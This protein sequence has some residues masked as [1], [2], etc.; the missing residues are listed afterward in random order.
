M[1]LTWS[2]PE[3][4]MKPMVY[5]TAVFSMVRTVH[6]TVFIGSALS[7]DETKSAFN[8]CC[9]SCSSSDELKSH[10]SLN[11]TAKHFKLNTCGSSF[12]EYQTRKGLVLIL[13]G[14]N[15][16]F[17]KT[18]VNSNPL[19]IIWQEASKLDQRIH[20]DSQNP[21]VLYEVCMVDRAKLFAEL[22]VQ[23]VS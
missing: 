18:N 15:A 20:S 21:M 10:H 2:A 4:M 11:S 19:I 3:G 5:A 8:S 7:T 16:K 6:F 13:D 9:I 23:Y 12:K 14:D 1:S 17:W 22:N